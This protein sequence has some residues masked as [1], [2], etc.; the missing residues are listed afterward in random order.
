[1]KHYGTMSDEKKIF[2]GGIRNVLTRDFALVYAAYVVF[3][4]ANQS[5]LPAMPIFLSKFGSSAREI[6][7]LIGVFAISSLVFRLAAGRVLIKYSEK[8]VMMGGAVL[9]ALTFFALIVF[10]P[11]WPIFVIRIFQGIAFAFL[12]TAAFTYS[13]NII[14]PAY[15]ARG[16]AYYMIAPNIA[17]AIAAPLGIF[18]INQY[19][20]TALFL[21]GAGMTLCAFCLPWNV[22]RLKDST[23]VHQ[24][25]EKGNQ[26]FDK[27]IVIPG[28]TG[29][30]HTL[31]F[32]GIT[33]FFPLYA[34]Q[35]G[36]T[37]PGHFF[38]ASALA[39]IAG[40]LFGGNV[41]DS[42]NKEKIIITLS[43]LSIVAMVIIA[44]SKTL[45][46]FVLAGVLQGVG[47]AFVNP[48]MMAYSFEYTGSS[49]GTVVAT[50]QALMDLGLAIGPL[51][52]G[53]ILPFTGYSLMFVCLAVIYLL[54]LFYFQFYVRKRPKSPSLPAR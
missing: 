43:S 19:S 53:I 31:I 5:L 28:F 47:V 32:G 25:P 36:V 20:F 13:L 14:P 38:S 40:R 42:F 48:A 8:T 54:S 24:A 2:Q 22:K 34:I 51:V 41:L 23:I 46:M 4:I 10:R 44:V 49:S 45:P 17:T 21:F 26:L 37:N 52:I 6:G 9:S 29:F 39:I 27:T 50:F 7:I 3:A 33:A 1:M 35:C 16:I 30:L 12:N 15:R 11:F 18:L